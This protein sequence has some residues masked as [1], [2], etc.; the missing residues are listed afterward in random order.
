[1]GLAEHNFLPTPTHLSNDWP[2]S[3]KFDRDLKDYP[4]T[5]ISSEITP[6]FYYWCR[7]ARETQSFSNFSAAICSEPP[8][9]GEGYLL[10][11]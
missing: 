6:C 4:I 2:T 10:L 3:N 5:T 8:R 11:W 1:M 7:R 9:K